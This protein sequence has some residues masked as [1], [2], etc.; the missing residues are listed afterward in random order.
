MLSKEQM[1]DQAMQDGDKD[2]KENAL[3]CLNFLKE[4]AIT[5]DGVLGGNYDV[6]KDT[7][8]CKAYV[9]Q[10]IFSCANLLLDKE[11]VA[12]EAIYTALKGKTKGI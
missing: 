7:P 11:R 4:G 10:L 6:F 5:E 12:L 3:G 2:Y 1:I 9:N 8:D